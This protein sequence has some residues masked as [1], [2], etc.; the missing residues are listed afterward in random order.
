MAKD[1]APLTINIPVPW[2]KR[3]AV[4]EAD[5]YV[6]KWIIVVAAV[7]TLAVIAI[8]LAI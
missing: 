3:P 4:V 7:T 8:W 2:S 6:A 5:R 1:N